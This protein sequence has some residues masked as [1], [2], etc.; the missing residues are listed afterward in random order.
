MGGWGLGQIDVL[1][2]SIVPALVVPAFLFLVLTG[3]KT[4][5]K[6]KCAALAIALGVIIAFPLITLQTRMIHIGEL[7]Q[8]RYMLPM[9]FLFGAIAILQSVRSGGIRL[10]SGQRHVLTGMLAIAQA[11]ALHFT[12]RRYASG[13][14]VIDWNLNVVVEWWPSY[15]LSPMTTWIIVTIAFVILAHQAIRVFAPLADE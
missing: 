9:I 4:T 14:D 3:I 12:I 11:V 6:G 15:L 2:P 5:S 10:G 1:L 7:V 8:P 13:T